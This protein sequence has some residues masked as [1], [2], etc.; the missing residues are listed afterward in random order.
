MK[1]HEPIEVH[2]CEDD[3]VITPEPPLDPRWSD[4]DKLRWKAGCLYASTGVRFEIVTGAWGY[5]PILYGYYGHS[6]GGD[7]SF[8]EM[9]TW[10]NGVETG[11]KATNRDKE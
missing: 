10:L 8:G 9:W 4:L 6:S 11:A 7:Y 3:S 5:D 1:M 2:F